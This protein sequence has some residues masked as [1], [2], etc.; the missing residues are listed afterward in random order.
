MGRAKKSTPV[1]RRNKKRTVVYLQRYNAFKKTTQPKLKAEHPNLHA[2]AID[3][4]LK[5][6]WAEKTDEEKKVTIE[7]NRTMRERESDMCTILLA[8][9]LYCLLLVDERCSFQPPSVSC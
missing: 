4:Q 1:S 8:C 7:I 2:T 5:E 3:K 9:L 6:M